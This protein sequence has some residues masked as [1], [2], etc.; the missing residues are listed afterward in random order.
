MLR[1]EGGRESDPTSRCITAAAGKHTL[2]PC[3][4]THARKGA[5]ARSRSEALYTVDFFGVDVHNWR[6]ECL[7]V[8]V[9]V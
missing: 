5:C 4:R 7:D 9:L 3:A 6:I 2:P 8:G 1:S